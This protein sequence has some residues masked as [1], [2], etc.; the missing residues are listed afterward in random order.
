MANPSSLRDLYSTNPPSW[1]FTPP[2]N[3]TGL[4]PGAS[5][6]PQPSNV[7]S[8]TF[9]SRPAQNSI[10]ELSPGL[11]EPGGL[12]LGLLVKTL[13]ASAVLGYTTTA[14][15]MPW[16]VGKCLLQVQWVPRDAGQVDD[17]ES[18]LEEVAEEVPSLYVRSTFVPQH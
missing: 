18:T 8:H 7:S 11:A 13:V 1:S 9:S 10:F 6:P 3:S 12:D 17:A 4:S 2:S 5:Q 15:A 16:E 14:I